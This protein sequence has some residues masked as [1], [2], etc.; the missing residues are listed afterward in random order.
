MIEILYNVF[1]KEYVL[2][3]IDIDNFKYIND[4]YGYEYG[5]KVLIIVVVVFFKIFNIKEICVRIG[6]DNF[7]IFVKYRDFFLEDIWEM[8]I[9]VIIFEL[10]MNVI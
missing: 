1:N 10:D 4:I 3:N 8:L 9:N 6:L 7:V 2:L 5:D